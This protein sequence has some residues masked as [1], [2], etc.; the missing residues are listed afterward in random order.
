MTFVPKE[1]PMDAAE[2]YHYKL[3]PKGLVVRFKDVFGL[4]NLDGYDKTA[5]YLALDNEVV[6]GRYNKDSQ[7]Y[8]HYSLL[9]STQIGE[10]GEEK[11]LSIE[12]PWIVTVS[13]KHFSLQ[14][15]REKD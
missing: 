13:G 6:F 10:D 8:L 12:M 7:A 1:E 2:S 9:G 14:L 5:V 15:R 3:I 4:R 11:T